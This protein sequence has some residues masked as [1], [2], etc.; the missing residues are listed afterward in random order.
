MGKHLISSEE[1]TG[2]IQQVNQGC[3]WGMFHIFDYHRWGVKR[4]FH[5]KKKRHARYKKKTSLQDQQNAVTDAESLK[6]SQHREISNAKGQASS[7]N[8]LHQKKD[9][10]TTTDQGSLNRDISI[11][12]KNNDDVLEVINVEKNALLKFLRDIDIGGKKIHQTPHNKAKLTKSGS[13][14]LTAPSKVKNI[15]SSTFRSKQTEIWH[16]PKGEKL[17]AGTQAPKKLGSSLVKD[18]SYETSKPSASDLG[19]DSVTAMQQKPSIS[20]R[21]SEGLS[22]KGWNQVVIHQFKAIKQKIKHALVEFKKSGHQ[23]SVEVIHNNEKEISQSLDVGVIQEYRKSKSLSEAKASESDSNKHEASL[24]R[25][26]SSLNES[27]DRYTQLFEKS[28]SKEIKWQSSKSKSLRLT[29]DDKIHKSRHA[30]MFSRSNLSM[31]NLES[32][33]FILHD[34]LI[35]T[36]EANNTVESDNDVQRKSVSVPLKIDKSLE[37]FKE[38][39][40]D[41]TVEGSARDVNPSSLSD[42]PAVKTSMTAYLSKEATTSLEISCQDNIISQA[43]GK[44]SNARSSNAS[45]TDIDTNNSLENHFLHF[46]SYPEN[47]S[48]FKYVKDILEFSGFMGNEQTQM[49]YTVDQPMKPSL[50]TALEEIF[51]HENECSEEENIN[52]CDHQLLFN[53]VNEVLFQIY[54]NSPTYFPKPFAFNY[55]L[56]P[57]PKGNYLVKEVWDS[58]SSYLRLRPELDQTLDDVVGRDLTK[59]SGWM[60]LQQEE[61]CVSLELEEM[62]IDDLLDEILFS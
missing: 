19:I 50:F 6:V 58:V 29:N 27:M 10:N 44:E 45:V 34:V 49:R 22:H 13:F 53:L 24:M 31:P 46:K 18:I 37:H 2:Q 33:G 61:E 35:D 16:F 25:R 38:A 21:P 36:N 26:T 55:K 15:S 5:C 43:E 4:V 40:V 23:A 11:K 42:N 41:E 48:N 8:A 57:M 54:E 62:I 52:M 51:L 56:K 9:V 1:S 3:M 20:S 47:D 60:N 39:E 7:G 30:R 12:F 14:P 59:G 17:L 32:L 28:M